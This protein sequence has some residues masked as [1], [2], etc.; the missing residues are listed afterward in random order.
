[1]SHSKQKHIQLF[2][3]KTIFY[4]TAIAAVLVFGL[5]SCSSELDQL[6]HDNLGEE[7]AY[8]T[9]QDFENAIRG[10]YRTFFNENYY[11][12]GDSGD[13]T[14]LSEVLADNVIR[15]PNGRGT[16]RGLYDY[17]FDP[18]NA[19]MGLYQDGYSLIYR[20]NVILE[21]IEETEFELEN[22]EDIIAEARALRGIA[23]FDMVKYYAKI[24]SQG[25]D[26]GLGIAYVTEADPEITPERGE[27]LET[28]DNIIEDLEYAYNIIPEQARD[29]R[30]NKEAIAL[31]LSRIYLYLA[32]DSDDDLLQKAVDYAAEVT[33][34]PAAAGDLADVFKDNTNAGLVFFISNIAGSDGLDESIG[35]T[36]SQGSLNDQVTA[37]FNVTKSLYDL[38]SDNDIRKN[39]FIAE[40]IDNNGN[41]GIFI[42]KYFGKDGKFDGIVNLK[43]LRAEEAILNRAEAE[44]KLGHTD[45]AREALDELRSIRYSDFSE[46]NESGDNLWEAIKLE[47]RLEFA[48]EYNRFLDL[49]RWGEDLNRSDNGYKADGSGQGPQR[50]HVENS[51][52]RFVLPFSQEAIN[53][54][55]KIK[56]NPGY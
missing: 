19:F 9:A 6:P 12:G 14:A 13:L 33:T 45:A 17:T 38:Y 55:P 25:G 32:Q 28:Y 2:D 47:R 8:E 53:R 22:K 27:L 24:P 23:H 46:G 4:K 40:G 18:A 16:K 3:M 20:A 39:A 50:E 41:E 44:Y 31:Y 49:K 11:G 29:G 54:N 5:I 30:L 35:V 52:T 51:D 15:N 36:W 7:V 43:V 48:F 56:Q 21:K 37:E 26:L 1:M 42:T 10:V 34:Q